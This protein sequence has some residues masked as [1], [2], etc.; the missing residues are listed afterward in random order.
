MVLERGR[1]LMD[2]SQVARFFVVN[3]SSVRRWGRQGRLGARK[4]R[5]RWYFQSAKV[6]RVWI[7]TIS[8]RASSVEVQGDLCEFL[9]LVEKLERGS[10][11]GL[12]EE[13]QDELRE[14][15][16]SI[17]ATRGPETEHARDVI[18]EL[19]RILRGNPLFGFLAR[20]P[21]VPIQ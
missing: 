11:A 18:L 10:V 17:L 19:A 5:G 20:V 1:T 15:A 14:M 8:G 9:D 21:I 7:P 6:L 13:T 16:Q 2:V 12:I 4:I 3:E